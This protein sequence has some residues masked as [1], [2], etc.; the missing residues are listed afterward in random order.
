M[1][2]GDSPPKEGPFKRIDVWGVNVGRA[3]AEGLIQGIGALPE[4]LT[5]PRLASAQVTGASSQPVSN[6]TTNSPAI[7]VNIGMY[8]GSPMEKRQIAKDLSDALADYNIGEG[9]LNA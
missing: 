8:A 5:S 6:Y 2:K 3:W 1:L 4:M 7:T 9:V